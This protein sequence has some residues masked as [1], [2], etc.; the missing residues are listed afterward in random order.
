MQNLSTRCCLTN[1]ILS[2]KEERRRRYMAGCSLFDFLCEILRGSIGR[3][4]HGAT[5]PNPLTATGA[6]RG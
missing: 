5:M 2:G 3:L 4:E 1:E 6:F